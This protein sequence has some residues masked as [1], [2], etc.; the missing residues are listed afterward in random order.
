MDN[1]LPPLAYATPDAAA[2]RLEAA[3]RAFAWFSLAFGAF[4]FLASALQV[5]SLWTIPSIGLPVRVVATL[6]VPVYVPM[7]IGGAWLLRGADAGT[8]AIRWSAL[9]M[10]I[11]SALSAIAWQMQQGGFT[12]SDVFALSSVY[13]LVQVLSTAIS[14]PALLFWLTY[15]LSRGPR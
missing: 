14:L 1:E 12:L 15:P 11:L 5:S 9:A 3:R 7:A 6:G 10:W 8:S 2:V 4:G 13:L